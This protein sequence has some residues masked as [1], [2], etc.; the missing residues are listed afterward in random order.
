MKITFTIY[1]ENGEKIHTNEMNIDE[2]KKMKLKLI[3]N[4]EIFSEWKL[5]PKG[6]LTEVS[7]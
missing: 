7:I 6:Y 4:N 1:L 5:D 3:E 2:A